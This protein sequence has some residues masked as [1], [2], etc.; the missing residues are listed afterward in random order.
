[1]SRRPSVSINDGD[2]FTT[3]ELVDVSV[4]APPPQPK[5]IGEAVRVELSN[6]GGFK[7]SKTFVLYDGKATVPWRLQSSRDGTFTKVVYVR[8]NSESGTVV[9]T[10]SDDI[11]FDSSKPVLAGVSVGARRSSLMPVEVFGSRGAKISSGIS[12][13]VRGSDTISGLATL[14]IRSAAN[15]PSTTV[16]FSQSNASPSSKVK[17]MTKLVAVTT[18]SKRLQ[19]RLIDRAGNSSAWKVVVL[20]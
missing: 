3:T 8:F 17:T 9:L 15:K 4:V 5:P 14:E 16:P 2:E 20:R 13:V 1:M 6:D 10:L 7:E 12:L 19:V 18:K 11:I